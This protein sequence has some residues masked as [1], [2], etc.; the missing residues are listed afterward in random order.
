MY[1]RGL[2]CLGGWFG[3]L[4]SL[5]RA[6]LAAFTKSSYRLPWHSIIDVLNLKN[7]NKIIYQHNNMT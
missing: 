2:D 7:D 6:N 4:T 1:S 5:F 3:L